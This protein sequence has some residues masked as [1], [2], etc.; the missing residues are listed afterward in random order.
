MTT[1]D[2]SSRSVFIDHLRFPARRRG[3]ALRGSQRRNGAAPRFGRVRRGADRGAAGGAASPSGVSRAVAHGAVAGAA[4]G[5]GRRGTVACGAAPRWSGPR[6]RTVP[7]PVRVRAASPCGSAPWSDAR[8]VPWTGMDGR[9]AER[10]SPGAAARTFCMGGAK[11]DRPA[12]PRAWGRL[13]F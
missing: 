13:Y 9:T 12:R 10:C 3:A 5:V 8:V 7:Q 11:P 1:G 2:S 4:P 6:R